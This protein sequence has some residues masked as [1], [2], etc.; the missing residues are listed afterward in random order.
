MAGTGSSLL[1]FDDW[2][3]HWQRSIF[4]WLIGSSAMAYVL[5]LSISY[6]L[7]LPCFEVSGKAQMTVW[8]FSNMYWMILDFCNSPWLI[9][10]LFSIILN[11][12]L[13]PFAPIDCSDNHICV[14]FCTNCFLGIIDFCSLVLDNIFLGC[15][16]W[17]ED[18]FHVT[19]AKSSEVLESVGNEWDYMSQLTFL[20]LY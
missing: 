6:I 18:S 8:S 12:S 15:V 16:V 3:P 9:L 14:E 20:K 4:S 13:L 2:Q 5:L 1:P 10:F 7:C 11:F 19:I 17:F